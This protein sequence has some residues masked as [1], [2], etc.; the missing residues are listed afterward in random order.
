MEI[1]IF[2]CGQVQGLNIMLCESNFK[3]AWSCEMPAAVLCDPCLRP[4]VCTLS[5][6]HLSFLHPSLCRISSPHLLAK[7]SPLLSSQ[8]AFRQRQRHSIPWPRSH[9]EN[10]AHV[11]CRTRTQQVFIAI[12]AGNS[13]TTWQG[14]PATCPLELER[15]VNDAGV[16]EFTCH[17]HT[18]KFTCRQSNIWLYETST[19]STF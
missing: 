2:F 9:G 10:M 14:S 3:N 8:M 12:V 16:R 4:T 18:Y 19:K 11:R 6:S 5:K 1:L 7:S 13:K 17:I 15:S